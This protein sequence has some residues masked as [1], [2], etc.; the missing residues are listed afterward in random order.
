VDSCLKIKFSSRL[1]GSGTLAP[2]ARSQI[3]FISLDISGSLAQRGIRENVFRKIWFSKN[4]DIK[5]ERTN[6]LWR[7]ESVSL[8]RHCLGHDYAILIVAQG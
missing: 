3:K 5:I 4:L 2:P 8:D 7:G 1:L 6:N